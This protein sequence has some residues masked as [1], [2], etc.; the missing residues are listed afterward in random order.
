M[1]ARSQPLLGAHYAEEAGRL[2]GVPPGLDEQAGAPAIRVPL[3]VENATLLPW[4]RDWTAA[5]RAWHA[6]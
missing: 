1:G 2:P 5:L 3:V 4:V 6:S